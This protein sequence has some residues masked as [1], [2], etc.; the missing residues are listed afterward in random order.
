MEDCVHDLCERGVSPGPFDA[1]P[2][3]K[4]PCLEGR[5]GHVKDWEGQRVMPFSSATHA[6]VMEITRDRVV[7]FDESSDEAFWTDSDLREVQGTFSKYRSNADR[8]SRETDGRAES[9]ESVGDV[10]PFL[11]P[12]T[13]PK[14]E[15]P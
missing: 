14:S 2:S 3:Y 15:K 6:H 12:P 5:H 7:V 13:L 8:N 4:L 10:P 11:V 9:I 1:D